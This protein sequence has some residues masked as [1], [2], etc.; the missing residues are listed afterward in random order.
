M[1]R[2]SWQIP[3]FTSTNARAATRSFFSSRKR[4]PEETKRPKIDTAYGS[5][6]SHDSGRH[7]N[8]N[9][10]TRQSAPSP[11]PAHSRP[12]IRPAACLAIGVGGR[13]RAAI[14]GMGL[15][16]DVEISAVLDSVGRSKSVSVSVRRR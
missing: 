8:F 1:W 2:R 14:A 7:I 16:E 4:Q 13:A 5:E 6:L 12:V 10:F 11:T 15:D 3:A 9:S